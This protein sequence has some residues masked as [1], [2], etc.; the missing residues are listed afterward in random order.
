MRHVFGWDLPPGVTQ[1]MID[2]AYGLDGPC[3]V[4]GEPAEDCG[5]PECPVCGE[6]GNP[7]CFG[8]H[9]P[10]SPDRE[11]RIRARE[12]EE[13]LW[14]DAQFLGEVFGLTLERVRAMTEVER[15]CWVE[16]AAV[17]PEELWFS[18]GDW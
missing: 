5:C 10:A 6:V 2:D 8:P 18:G 13:L 9:M 3:E 16:L 4:C 14:A 17:M 1:R 12:R 7:K 11:E 15:E